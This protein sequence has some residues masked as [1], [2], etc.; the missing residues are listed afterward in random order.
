MQITAEQSKQLYSF[1][2]L[3]HISMYRLFQVQGQATFFNKFS[4]KKKKF[5]KLQTTK[6][7]LLECSKQKRYF[8]LSF[9]SMHLA[10]MTLNIK[11]AFGWCNNTLIHFIIYIYI[12]IYIYMRNKL[13]INFKHLRKRDA[14]LS[15]MCSFFYTI[16][17]S[18]HANIHWNS[19]FAHF[20]CLHD[21]KWTWHECIVTFNKVSALKI[22]ATLCH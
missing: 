2:L 6:R 14:C 16:F 11:L 10:V 7:K 5:A 15:C 4:Y 19:I 8:R 1:T 12:Y 21:L 22:Y 17:I 18:F 20:K 3:F 13:Y 9:N